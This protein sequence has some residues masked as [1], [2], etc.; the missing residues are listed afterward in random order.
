MTKLEQDLKSYIEW[1][2]KMIN[3]LAPSNSSAM[4]AFHFLDRKAREDL[5]SRLSAAIIENKP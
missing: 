3:E 1:L 5:Y 4:M 2:H